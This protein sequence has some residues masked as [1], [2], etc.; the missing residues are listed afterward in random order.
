MR[1]IKGN[2]L[3]GKQVLNTRAHDFLYNF[4]LSLCVFNV[5]PHFFISFSAVRVLPPAAHHDLNILVGAGRDRAS[6]PQTFA[7]LSIKFQSIDP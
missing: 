2:N 6:F 1:V 5:R 7:S 4:F 3:E